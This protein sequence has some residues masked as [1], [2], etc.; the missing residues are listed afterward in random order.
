MRSVGAIL[1][2]NRSL[3]FFV[4]HA[5]LLGEQREIYEW[6]GLFRAALFFFR[7]F[8]FFRRALFFIKGALSGPWKR[9]SQSLRRL[10]GKKIGID[11]SVKDTSISFFVWSYC[12]KKAKLMPPWILHWRMS[13][14]P[15][16]SKTAILTNRFRGALL[17]KNV[18]LQFSQGTVCQ[19]PRHS[20]CFFFSKIGS[21]NLA[22]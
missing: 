19:V 12:I 14:C 18:T 17:T 11:K 9:H 5:T 7:G 1:F 8:F 16:H 3:R 15:I 21:R 4:S 13:N 22:Y 6:I 2:W 20:C 10:W